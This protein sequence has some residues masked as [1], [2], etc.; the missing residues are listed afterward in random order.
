[1]LRLVFWLYK[2][3]TCLKA[4]PNCST[5]HALPPLR[6]CSSVASCSHRRAHIVVPLSAAPSGDGSLCNLPFITH[7]I[8]AEGKRRL[9]A[10]TRMGHRKQSNGFPDARTTHGRPAVRCP[11][12]GARPW[13]HCHALRP[14]G[15]VLTLF[16][17]RRRPSDR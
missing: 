9:L 16:T 13:E 3:C 1:M 15:A 10:H 7:M 17:R 8:L 12:C 4:T 11:A 14:T 2:S 6:G 5:D